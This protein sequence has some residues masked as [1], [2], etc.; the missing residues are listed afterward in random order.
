MINSQSQT[1]K[2]QYQPYVTW[3]GNNY[4]SASLV[5]ARPETNGSWI[6]RKQTSNS[7]DGNAFLPRPMK[8]WRKQLQANKIRGGTKNVNIND[9]DSPGL[10]NMLNNDV[11]CGVSNNSIVSNIQQKNNSTIYDNSESI[12][13]QTDV[14]N[15]WDGPIGKRICCNP[16]NNLITYKTAPIEKNFISYQY[17]FKNRCYNYEQNISTAKVAG[18][19]YFNNGIATYPS[20][21]PNGCQILQKKNCSNNCCRCDCQNSRV[22]NMIYKP[23]NRQ[24]AKQGGTS[25]KSRI[26]ALRENTIN[27]GGSLFNNAYG[28]KE[29]NNGICNLNGDS[30]YYVKNKPTSCITTKCGPAYLKTNQ[31][32][33]S[34]ALGLQ[35][36]REG[37][38]IA[39]N[40]SNR[41]VAVGGGGYSMLYSNDG[42]TWNDVSGTKFNPT[43]GGISIFYANNIWVA[44]GS[45]GVNTILYSNDGITWSVA[46]GT[47][48]TSSGTS[49]YYGNNL[50]V[51]S[52][53]GGANTI[54]Y[55]LDGKT[56]WTASTGVNFDNF[57]NKFIYKGGLWVA[58]GRGTNTI[59]YSN[60]GMN[61][62]TVMGVQFTTEGFSIEYA[63]NI[64]VAVGEGTN[65]ILYSNN[66]THWNIATGAT[67]SI[68]GNSIRYANGIWVAVGQGGNSIL[69]SINGINWST[70]SGTQFSGSFSGGED[71][72]Y[73][74]D[75][76]VSVGNGAE[77]ETVTSLDGLSWTIPKGNGFSILGFGKN[78]LY[79]NRWVALGYGL[80][81]TSRPTIIYGEIVE[82]IIKL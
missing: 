26:N 54:L 32:V 28:L 25:G 40:G 80:G 65:K 29:I 46:T 67:F 22:Q 16:E 42:I 12:I 72:N 47:L 58:V 49:I 59:L 76:W 57:G 13:T 23:N 27:P 9:I 82:E 7:R 21:N 69:Y 52:G 18:N 34:V 11:C 45:G 61:W 4:N 20:N 39:Y 31:L 75:R 74:I 50:W 66:G 63:N 68:R 15:C 6:L 8:Q 73:G 41:W 51:A 77:T 33:W 53:Y 35:F 3:K 37:N 30:L 14:S 48:F 10:Y 36:T 81:I 78:V 64:W 1:Y 2:W 44:V 55:S 43:T 79:G 24:F 60:D 5:N 17:Y 56:N 70:V 62:N 19:S 38:D 71:V